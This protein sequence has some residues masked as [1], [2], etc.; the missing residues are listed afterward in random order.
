MDVSN[1]TTNGPDG[2]PISPSDRIVAAHLRLNDFLIA[3]TPRDP[4]QTPLDGGSWKKLPKRQIVDQIEAVLRRLAWLFDHDAELANAHIARLRLTQLLR[5]LYTVKLPCTE[6]DLRMMLDLTTP[7]LGRIAPDGPLAYVA[8]YLKG[9]DLTPELCQ[10]LREFASHLR[11]EMSCGQASMQS[12]R[13]TLHVVLW[14]DEWEP[15][16]PA[17]CWSEI[18]RRDFRAMVGVRRAAWRRL[19]KQ[20]RGNAP[21][22]M[23]AGWV[24][25]AEAR[26]NE[27]GVADFREQL[28]VWFAPFCSGQPLPL[29]VAGSHVLKG[30]IWYAALTRDEDVKA[31]ALGLL[32]VKWKQKR[33]VEKSMVALEV[34]GIEKKDLIARRLINDEPRAARNLIDRFMQ[35]RFVTTADRFVADDDR[36]VIIVQGDLH[37]YRLFRSARRIERAGDNAVLELD[38]HALPDSFRLTI[39][40]ACDS[41]EQLRRRGLLLMQDAT[42]G[43]CFRVVT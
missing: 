10:R 5:V 32:D 29:S 2:F 24:R 27:V 37:F 39:S 42:Y 31:C 15:L 35:S 8:A 26:L 34:F 9:E 41:E 4:S 43:R 20:I 19:L 17:R 36:D 28:C 1:T 40:Q 30:L 6:A 16:D 23:P 7:L 3:D 12:I 13:Q 25:D 18:V 38:W 21:T 11:E 14:L 33:N 22:R